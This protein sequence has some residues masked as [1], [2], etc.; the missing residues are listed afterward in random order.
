MVYIELSAWSN[1]TGLLLPC[2]LQIRASLNSFLERFSDW[3]L[4]WRYMLDGTVEVREPLPQLSPLASPTLSSQQLTLMETR[5]TGPRSK[6]SLGANY[7]TSDKNRKSP[8]TLRGARV[9]PSPGGNT[10]GRLHRVSPWLACWSNFGNRNAP[11]LH[12]D[13]SCFQKCKNTRTSKEPYS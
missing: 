1:W 2:S 3:T 12:Y 13:M 8:R 4:Q 6:T 11:H 9:A 10:Q 7:S 5:F